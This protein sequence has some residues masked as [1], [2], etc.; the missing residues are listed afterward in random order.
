[1]AHEFAHLELTTSNT[2]Q[3]KE[4]YKKIFN[5]KFTPVKGMPYT[6]IETKKGAGGGLTEPMMAGAPTAWMP[7]VSVDDVKATLIKAEKAGAKIVQP[8]HD[9]GMGATGII[10]DPTGAAIGVWGPVEKVPKKKAAKKKKR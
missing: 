2:K 6:M 4:F 9:I 8:Y 5:W 10:L 3:A 7:Y 1:M